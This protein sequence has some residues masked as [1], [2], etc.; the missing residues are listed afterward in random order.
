MESSFEVRTV[1]P[2]DRDQLEKVAKFLRQYGPAAGLPFSDADVG[3]LQHDL[4]G[5]RLHIFYATDGK[6]N[7]VGHVSLCIRSE[8]C[9]RTGYASL[10]LVREDC[11]GQQVAYD[12]L[13]RL[14]AQAQISSCGSIETLCLP[15]SPAHGLVTRLGYKLVAPSDRHWELRLRK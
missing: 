8:F 3:P 9:G 5:N 6:M 13:M 11:R 15:Q 7:V 10:L 4:E 2:R 12:L 1:R 14:K